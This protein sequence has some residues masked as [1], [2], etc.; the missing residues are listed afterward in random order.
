[1][2]KKFRVAEAEAVIRDTHRAGIVPQLFIMA[3]FP[4]ET[5]ADFQ[6]TLD[7][8]ERNAEF[9]GGIM[10]SFCEIQKGSHLDRHVAEYDVRL[11]LTDRTHWV[12]KDGSNTYEVR[13]DRC[14]RASRLIERLGLSI[15]KVHTTKVG[16]FASAVAS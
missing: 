16:D 11:P 5:E 6:E 12:S 2:R 14:A 3:G 8:I 4:G 13:R 9:I 15:N 10:V 1:M 7:F